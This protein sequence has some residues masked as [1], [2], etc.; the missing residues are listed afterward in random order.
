M[1]ALG[2]AVVGARAD[3]Q[4]DQSDHARPRRPSAT[5]GASRLR[6]PVP[7]GASSTTAL[8]DRL[9]HRRH[10]PAQSASSLRRGDV[11]RSGVPIGADTGSMA[12][13]GGSPG[14]ADSRVPI[15]M[16]AP[17][18]HSHRIIGL[19][20]TRIDGDG[21]TR[22]RARL[23]REI[24]VLG[25]P[26]P[27]RR[28]ADGRRPVEVG[29]DRR[30]VDLARR[31]AATLAFERAFALRIVDLDGDRLEFERVAAP[32]DDV[33]LLEL[34]RRRVREAVRRGERDGD[35]DHA[36]VDDHAAVGPTDEA[37][38]ALP[39]GGERRAGAAPRPR[40]TRR[41]RTR[42]AA[43]S[44]RRRRRRRTRSPPTPPHAGQNSRVAQQFG[45][46]P[47]ATEAPERPP[48]GTAARARSASTAGRSTARRRRSGGPGAPRRAAG[49]PCRAARRTRTP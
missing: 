42:R 41:A 44:R 43:P 35:H 18:I 1:S 27:H 48:S 46:S 30:A 6:P 28:G 11:T 33:A 16:T 23:E 3:E 14:N 34:E 21:A 4:H 12:F 7:S 45:R 36:E 32:F 24:D 10:L 20:N 26:G 19:T 38:P 9:S 5:H 39:A 47:C 49:R 8:V 2:A 15:A 22:L 25:D 40:R 37:A 31:R 13:G 17:P 29:R